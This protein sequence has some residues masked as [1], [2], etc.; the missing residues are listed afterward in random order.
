MSSQLPPE[1]DDPLFDT[2]PPEDAS[3]AS[4]TNVESYYAILNLPLTATSSEIQSS[5]RRL[6]PLLHPDRHPSPSQKQAADRS[7]QLLQTAFEVLSDPHKRAIYDQ[8]GQ[9]GLKVGMEIQVKG[10]TAKEMREEF[11]KLAR[12][13]LEK[14]VEEMVRSRGELTLTLDARVFC[15]GDE[16][17][18]SLGGPKE[19]GWEGKLK[20]VT[21]RQM[22]LKHSFVVS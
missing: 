16:E 3:E 18:R 17:R 9:A 20:S 22:F 2:T 19:L 11:E 14:N 10:K 21:Q 7:F 5:Y 1:E 15:L 12:E 8:F 6:A 4:S 13:R